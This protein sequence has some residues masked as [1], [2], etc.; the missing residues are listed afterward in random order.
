MK[1]NKIFCKWTAVSLF[2]IFIL[3][4]GIH[5]QILKKKSTLHNHDEWCSGASGNRFGDEVEMGDIN[6][7]GYDDIVVLSIHDRQISVF[8]GFVTGVAS[9]EAEIP[10]S[11]NGATIAME[12]TNGDEYQDVIVG[13]YGNVIFYFGGPDKKAFGNASHSINLNSGRTVTNVSPIGDFNNDGINDIIAEMPTIGKAFVVFG[14]SALKGIPE[15]AP[16]VISLYEYRKVSGNVGDLNK[17]GYGD[18]IYQVKK[19]LNDPQQVV[20]SLGPGKKTLWKAVNKQTGLFE[21]I[22]SGYDYSMAETGVSHY[23]AIKSDRTLWAWGANDDGQLGDGTTESKSDPV[24]ITANNNWKSVSA[25][26]WHTVAVRTDGTLWAWGN[27]RE[28]QLGNN[29]TNNASVPVRIGTNT[30][31][32]SVAAGSFHTL[33]IQSDGSLWAWGYN[34]VGQLGDG[35][36]NSSLVP[37]KIG[38]DKNWKTITT[39]QY[40]NAAIKT[41]GTLWM[42]GENLN[43]QLGDGTTEKSTSPK[44]VGTDNTWVDVSVGNSHTLA[45]K[46]DGSLWGWGGNRYGQLGDGTNTTRPVPVRIG[47]DNDWVKISCGVQHSVGLKSNGTLWYWGYNGS[48]SPVQAGSDNTWITALA[49]GYEDILAL[50]SADEIYPDWTVLG[51]ETGSSYLFGSACGSAGDINNDGFIDIMIGDGVFNQTPANTTHLGKW[52]KV[53]IYFGGTATTTNPTGL[54]ENPTL[55]DADFT[56]LGDISAGSF[57]SALASG[58]INGDQFGDIAIGDPRAADYCFDDQTENTKIVETGAVITYLSGLGPPDGDNDGYHNTIDNCPNVFNP[59]QENADGDSHG[60]VCDNCPSVK[61]DM[62]EDSDGDG[63]GDACDVCTR[64]ATNDADGDGYC[65]GPGYMEP[66]IG[67]KDNCPDIANPDQKDLDDDG[68]GDVCDDDDDGDG[69]AD[70][71]DNCPLVSNSSQADMNSNG[72]GDVCDDLDGDGTVD[73]VDNCPWQANANQSDRDE[74]GIGDVCDNC[75]DTPN[76][77]K[78]GTCSNSEAPCN[79]NICGPSGACI[80]TQVDTDNDGMGDACDPDDD[81]DGIPDISDNCR[82]TYNPGQEDLDNDGVGDSCNNAYDRDGDEWADKLDNCPDVRNPDQKDDNKNGIGDACEHD[83]SCIRVEVTQAIQD[84]NNS[85]PIVYGKDIWIRLYFDVGAAQDT[86]GPISG[87][88]KFEYENKAP[89]M[90]Y[91]NSILRRSHTLYSTSQIEALPKADFDPLNMHH[92]LNFRIPR[93]WSFAEDPYMT[94]IVFYTGPDLNPANN[95]PRRFKL[96]LKPAIQLNVIVVPVYGCVPIMFYNSS[97]SRCKPATNNTINVTANWM[98]K[99]YPISRLRT[100]YTPSHYFSVDPTDNFAYGLEL[101]H[102]LFWIDVFTDEPDDMEP[103]FFYGMVCDALDPVPDILNG[104]G[105]TGMGMGWEAWGVRSG[106]WETVSDLQGGQ[107]MAHEIGHCIIG[108]QGAGDWYEFWPAHVRDDCAN[109]NPPFFDNYPPSS[110]RGLIDAIGFDGSKTY[111]NKEYYDFMSYAPCPG[112]PGEGTWVS[113]YIYKL[114]YKELYNTYLSKKKSTATET[115]CFVIS[116]IIDRTTPAFTHKC[117]Q[118]EMQGT[119]NDVG[120]G[121][122]SIELQDNSNNILFTRYFRN[123]YRTS[124][125]VETLDDFISFNEVLPYYPE[126]KK[127]LIKYGDSVLQTIMV[128]SNKPLVTVTYPNGGESLDGIQTVTWNASDADGDLLSFDVLYSKDGGTRWEAI[129]TGVDQTSCVWDVEDCGGSEEGLIKVLATDGVNTGED[130][131]DGVFRVIKK[132]PQVTILSPDNNG[133]FYLNRPVEFD[134]RGYDMEDGMLEGNSLTWSSDLDGVLSKGETFLTD[135]LSPGEHV[136]TLSVTD[137]DNNTVT[138]GV[139][140]LILTTEDSDGDGIG[141]DV[142]EKPYVAN[143]FPEEGS[144]TCVRNADKDVRNIL[145]NGNFGD[146]ALAPWYSFIATDQGVQSTLSL[147]DGTCKLSGFTISNDPYYWHV[148]LIQAFTSDQLARL[149]SGSDYNLSFTTYSLSGS[150][151]CHVYFGLNNDPWTDLVNQVIEIPGEPKTYSFDFSYPSALSSVKLAFELGTDTAAVVFDDIRLKKIVY[152]KDHDGIEDKDD[153]C[154]NHVNPDQ[155]DTDKDGIGDVCD[156]Q[157]PGQNSTLDKPE[158]NIFPNPASDYIT[159][160]LRQPATVT[161]FNALGIAVRMQWITDVDNSIHVNDLP[162]GLYIIKVVTE[163]SI[164]NEQIVIEHKK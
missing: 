83:L 101:K 108:N 84:A 50:K 146:C 96:N 72:I 7:D 122:Y 128:S 63:K 111:S 161:V 13:E 156:T 33:A 120:E 109:R 42:W 136:I 6:N 113:T 37:V 70:A 27:N 95:S 22:S 164:S 115:F 73:A 92:T 3:I 74:D 26:L 51:T 18:Y 135:S 5:G 54:G 64:D 133:L 90:I 114:L 157:T 94:F 110:P 86:L 75:P 137:S 150:R 46:N 148:Q 39:Y 36:N 77:P 144:Q 59:Y 99:V 66:K 131:S 87:M 160:R 19:N 8:F 57:G 127:I 138:T 100:A 134:G 56:M 65:N 103:S 60:D 68:I 105:Q 30:N 55:A 154:P 25:G 149:V 62:Q 143:I 43:S 28:G 129:A 98:T 40:H 21:Q 124:D 139:S 116:G 93:H 69:I 38:N 67:D 9:L 91:E 89:M 163:K 152:D 20:V 76:G 53:Y 11:E 159:I 123:F 125:S 44:Q 78:K 4:S 1:P 104:D 151:E 15:R 2:L 141:D 126:T 12:N 121:P 82:T 45:I 112:S 32:I 24:K 71:I 81:N 35:T 88:I 102:E 52:G 29:S 23:M 118:L 41:D 80:K 153:N 140:I 142:D 61:N 47:S 162:D 79:Y 119:Y 147:S 155:A 10:Y 16:Q 85:V 117:H 17:D 132:V 31:W 106:Y 58:D 158:I 107:T 14:F 48:M 130:V 34:Y 49:G 145:I 97:T